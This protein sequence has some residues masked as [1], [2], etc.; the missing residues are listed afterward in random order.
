MN[1]TTPQV[2]YAVQAKLRK[3]LWSWCVAYS[4]LDFSS[5]CN[6][7]PHELRNLLQPKYFYD[8]CCVD[9]L[10]RLRWLYILASDPL[11]PQ[12]RHAMENACYHGHIRVVKWLMSLGPMPK[13]LLSWKFFKSFVAACGQGHLSI[14]Q[15][16]HKKL[17]FCRFMFMDGF[18]P[19]REACAGGHLN[20]AQWLHATFH[21]SKCEA[22]SLTPYTFGIVCMEGHL[23]VAQW[24]HATFDM[25]EV[26]AGEHRNIAL[27]VA[28]RYQHWALVRWLVATF[29]LAG[30][31]DGLVQLVKESIKK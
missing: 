30:L 27:H 24:L 12:H 26:D 25:D 1:D 17:R 21:L 11:L 4:L 7:L 13:G 10:G 6:Y 14:A 19:F 15:K 22:L 3:D 8:M 18:E 31:D 20:V 28:C 5:F 23:H 29:G 16:M 2:L 9:D